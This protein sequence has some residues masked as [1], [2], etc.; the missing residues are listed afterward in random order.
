MVMSVWYIL[1]SYVFCF[2]VVNLFNTDDSGDTSFKDMA[3]AGF[4]WWLVFGLPI[5]LIALLKG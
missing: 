5:I 4:L 2:I 3:I 1:A